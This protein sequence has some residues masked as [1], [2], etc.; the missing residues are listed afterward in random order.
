VRAT[1]SARLPDPA[2]DALRRRLRVDPVRLEAR[3]VEAV[4]VRAAEG[5][6]RGPSA[7]G[8]AIGAAAELHAPAFGV[9]APEGVALALLVADRERPAVTRAEQ[10]A[11]ELLGHLGGLALERLLL[12]L[13]LT[14]LAGEVRRFAASAQAVAAETLDGRPALPHERGELAVFPSA[15]FAA[16]DLAELLTAREAEIAALL[17]QGRT[18][19]EI[20]ET[21][22]LSPATVKGYVERLLRKLGASNRAEAVARYLQL[23]AASHAR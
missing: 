21:L 7:K 17:V 1:T 20:A 8:S 19:R 15:G 4:L 2:S 23:S 12:R 18:N 5:T 11:V 22:V 10:Q 9:L 16:A 6:T 13:R 3:S 14:E